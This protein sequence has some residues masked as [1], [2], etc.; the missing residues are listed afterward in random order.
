MLLIEFLSNFLSAF[1]L[2]KCLAT[3]ELHNFFF[4]TG[5]K[6][7]TLTKATS[8]NRR[9]LTSIGSKTLA[10][11]ST[12]ASLALVSMTLMVLASFFNLCQ[13]VTNKPSLSWIIMQPTIGFLEPRLLHNIIP[14]C[15]NR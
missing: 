8:F 3:K 7:C 1:K 2:V 12:L 9:E 11:F 5:L 6:K 13:G 15:L 14:F 4:S 10:L